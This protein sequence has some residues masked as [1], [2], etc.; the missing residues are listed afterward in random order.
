[1]PK[2]A[3]II[4]RWT[5]GWQFVWGNALSES[6]LYLSRK[7]PFVTKVTYRGPNA[8]RVLKDRLEL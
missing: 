7:W 6:Y 4:W 2:V 5:D 8:A 3:L 1:M